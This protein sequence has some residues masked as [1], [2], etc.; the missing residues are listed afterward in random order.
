MITDK[1]D[2]YALAF[3][4]SDVLHAGIPGKELD[5]ISVEITLMR[6][7]ENIPQY[8]PSHFNGTVLQNPWIAHSLNDSKSEYLPS[9]KTAYINIG[10]GI[11]DWTGWL[12]LDS[13]E[14]PN[15]L[16]YS[17]SCTS[18]I[19]AE[20]GTAELIYSSHHIE[21]VDIP[22]FDRMI[23]EC[24]RVINPSNGV[25]LLKFPDY[26]SILENYTN[27]NEQFFLNKG[28]EE[29]SWS[30]R[31]K[32]VED[33]LANRASMLFC[34]YWNKRYGDHFSGR[35]NRDQ[36]SYH[37]PA[38][39]DSRELDTLLRSSSPS[40][41]A[42][43]LRLICLEDSEFSCFNHQSAWSALE[44]EA[45]LNEAGL[46]VISQDKISI[47][48]KFGNIIPDLLSYFEWSRYVLAKKKL[49]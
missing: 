43:R 35:I 22:T 33:N 18:T 21:H 24:S 25:V 6:S 36:Y 49:S 34:G 26:D 9:Y 20:Q 5:R 45:G 16:K 14:H 1:P 8:N 48:N 2:G 23:S 39:M 10:S 42:E 38:V 31:H 47:A 37:G 46:S 41:I 3:R 17:A 32:G 27:G 4:N 13:L 12:L 44:M 30:W 19:P 15:V 28:I 11:R 40:K 7:L 29:V